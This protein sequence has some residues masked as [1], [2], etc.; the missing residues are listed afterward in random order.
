MQAL[1]RL[2][3]KLKEQVG[4]DE[5]LSENFNPQLYGLTKAQT[6]KVNAL[7]D[8]VT[9]YVSIRED[10]TGKSIRQKLNIHPF[11]ESTPVVRHSYFPHISLF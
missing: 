4:L 9:A 2:G 5:L 3:L 6:E 8:V 11:V 7:R 10:I 1:E